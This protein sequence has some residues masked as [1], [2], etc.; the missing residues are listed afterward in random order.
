MIEF[1]QS[2]NKICLNF[3]FNVV[4]KLAFGVKWPSGYHTGLRSHELVGHTPWN[5]RD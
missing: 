4:L 1:L 2:N 3:L 5:A